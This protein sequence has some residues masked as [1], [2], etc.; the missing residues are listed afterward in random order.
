MSQLWL[1]DEMRHTAGECAITREALHKL[2]EWGT[3]EAVDE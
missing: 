3:K 2:I 1:K